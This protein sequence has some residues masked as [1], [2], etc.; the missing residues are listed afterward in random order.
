MF[1]WAGCLISEVVFAKEAK[2]IIVKIN[3]V[4]K[5][6]LNNTFLPTERLFSKIPRN[7]VPTIE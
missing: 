2:H 5:T 7:S 4:G 3:V 6:T 1:D